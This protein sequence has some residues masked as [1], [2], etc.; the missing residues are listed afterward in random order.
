[1]SQ[2]SFASG[3]V[4]E[5]RDAA[6]SRSRAKLQKLQ[7]ALQAQVMAKWQVPGATISNGVKRHLPD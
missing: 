4:T 7:R 5:C 2:A 1:M 6:G 3:R